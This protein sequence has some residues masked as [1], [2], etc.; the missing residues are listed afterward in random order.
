[1]RVGEEVDEVTRCHVMIRV[2]CTREKM[3]FRSRENVEGNEFNAV[4][5]MNS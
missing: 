5:Q 4:V 2:F 1:M 3:K